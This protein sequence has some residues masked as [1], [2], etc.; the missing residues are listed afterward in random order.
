MSYS[1][2]VRDKNGRWTKNPKIV[3]SKFITICLL[4]AFLMFGLAYYAHANTAYAEK[5]TPNGEIHTGQPDK[6]C[7]TTGEGTGRIESYCADT[8]EN[9]IK[10][11]KTNWEEPEEEPKEV[12]PTKK[13]NGN[14]IKATLSAYS[15]RVQ[16]TDDTPCIS[17]DGSNIC[18]LFAKG[19]MICASNDFPMHSIIHIE[20]F[21]D[22]II[23]DRMNRRYTGTNR[24]DLYYG[25]DT[26]SALKHGVKKV[27]VYEKKNTK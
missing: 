18:E 10:A 25:Y 16:E 21:G 3:N 13:S 7:I 8:P 6:V 26:I 1:Q 15:S 27:L 20:G 14:V 19:E 5:G 2:L 11:I 9:L 24:I 12:K 22:C 17:A 23:R 4:I